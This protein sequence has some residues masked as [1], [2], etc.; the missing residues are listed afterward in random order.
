MIKSYVIILNIFLIGAFN[1]TAVYAGDWSDAFYWK[2]GTWQPLSIP[3]EA[4]DSRTSGIAVSGDVVCVSGSYSIQYGEDSFPCYWRNGVLQTLS[5]PSGAKSGG[6]SGIAV[7]SGVVYVVG[8]YSTQYGSFPCYWKNGMIQPMNLPNEVKNA[9][10]SGITVSGDVVYIPGSYSTQY[11]DF[12]CYWKNGIIQNAHNL[13]IP[14]G[15]KD[16]CIGGITI[17]D[18]V[19]YVS[20]TY[21][22]GD[23]NKEGKAIPCY[24]RNGVIN[25]L[26]LPSGSVIWPS[27]SINSITVV[28][29]VVYI[30]GSYH[31]NDLLDDSIPCYWKNGTLHN[32][33][34][35]GWNAGSIAVSNNAIYISGGSGLCYWR[36]GEI[37]RFSSPASMAGKYARITGI[38]V[39]GS[40]VYIAT[41]FW[42]Q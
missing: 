34:L 9:W 6:T 25:N 28:G 7:S 18:G 16:Y 2:N 15:V 1:V 11:G 33:S 26:N 3:R 30:A 4:K 5:L 23:W 32:L 13:N 40:S 10:A 37:H 31:A 41:N 35:P 36:D 12:F 19:V 14:S 22:V 42:M 27:G 29:N 24:W 8:W 38:A 39:S 20:G 21:I 17:S